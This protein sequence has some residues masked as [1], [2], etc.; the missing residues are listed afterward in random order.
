[1]SFKKNPLVYT[2]SWL[3]MQVLSL[4]V[5]FSFSDDSDDGLDEGS[6]LAPTNPLLAVKKDPDEESKASCRDGQIECGTLNG[7][8]LQGTVTVHKAVFI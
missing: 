3:K 4:F 2:Y 8:L 5:T 6:S 1:M 7:A